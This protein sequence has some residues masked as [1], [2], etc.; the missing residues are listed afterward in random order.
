MNKTIFDTVK[1]QRG[2]FCSGLK[3]CSVVIFHLYLAIRLHVR[4]RN[5]PTDT[6]ND[7][8]ALTHTY[9]QKKRNFELTNH[10]LFCLSYFI[11]EHALG[12]TLQSLCM[13]V[14]RPLFCASKSDFF[15]IQDLSSVGR[16]S[17]HAY[18]AVLQLS[19]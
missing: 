15:F 3:I 2:S 18:V 6:F 5:A 17:F 12:A 19:L 7:R 16:F 10:L 1:L 8:Q 11:N 13:I 14:S 9:L 4:H